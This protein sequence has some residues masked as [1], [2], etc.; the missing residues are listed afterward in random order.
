MVVSFVSHCMRHCSF[1][2]AC[3]GWCISIMDYLKEPSSQIVFLY[4]FDIICLYLEVNYL[5]H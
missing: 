4:I 1:P 5:W 3:R 2:A